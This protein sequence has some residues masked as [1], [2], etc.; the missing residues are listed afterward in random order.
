MAR[1]QA[2]IDKIRRQDFKGPGLKA[3]FVE[4]IPEGSGSGDIEPSPKKGEDVY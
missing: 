2:A 3:G 1:K 4:K